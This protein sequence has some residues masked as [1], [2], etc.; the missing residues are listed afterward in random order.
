[1]ICDSNI[2]KSVGYISKISNKLVDS[3]LAFVY[4][5]FISYKLF[6]RYKSYSIIDFMC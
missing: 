5:E 2:L 6:L 1:M 4:N 3:R